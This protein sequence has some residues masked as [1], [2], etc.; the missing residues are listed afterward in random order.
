MH[1]QINVENRS[2]NEEIEEGNHKLV[3]NLRT[4]LIHHNTRNTY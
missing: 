2:V 3:D 4:G 1:M